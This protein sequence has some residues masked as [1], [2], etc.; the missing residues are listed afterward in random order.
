MR[1]HDNK[2]P[3]SRKLA[4]ITTTTNTTGTSMDPYEAG[5]NIRSK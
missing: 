2:A 1:S 4:G 3:A 5:G